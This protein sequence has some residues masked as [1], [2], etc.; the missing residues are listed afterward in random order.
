MNKARRALIKERLRKI[1]NGLDEFYEVTN[2][3]IIF[4][5]RHPPRGSQY[6]YE[7]I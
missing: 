6:L 7:H 5:F 2:T 1:P 4:G 3:H